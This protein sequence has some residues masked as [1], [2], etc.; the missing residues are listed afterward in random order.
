LINF[1]IS[2]DGD[3]TYEV[4]IFVNSAPITVAPSILSCAA[5]PF[6]GQM[7]SMSVIL[8]LA[9][10]DVLQ[11]VYV[12]NDPDTP[13][14]VLYATNIIGGPSLITAYLAIQLLQGT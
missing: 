14:L 7:S 4:A 5:V 2:A 13:Q 10:S 12:T 8:S 1:G 6:G 9:A 3:A 11:V